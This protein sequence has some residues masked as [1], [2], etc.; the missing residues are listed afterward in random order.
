MG[1]MIF[2]TCFLFSLSTFAIG[3]A[4]GVAGIVDHIDGAMKN[5]KKNNTPAL[6]LKAGFKK[7]AAAR[8]SANRL[9]SLN[10]KQWSNTLYNRILKRSFADPQNVRRNF[11]YYVNLERTALKAHLKATNPRYGLVAGMMISSMLDS[12]EKFTMQKV[13]LDGK[14]K[15]LYSKL[16]RIG[17]GSRAARKTLLFIYGK[18]NE[19]KALTDKKIVHRMPGKIKP[20]GLFDRMANVGGRVLSRGKIKIR[21]GGQ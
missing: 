8:H 18:S 13:N 19:L 9:M 4:A 1:K 2:I 10:A 17:P 21:P 6:L 11:S 14:M 3:G 16:L 5:Y 7:E 20:V 15:A 12:I